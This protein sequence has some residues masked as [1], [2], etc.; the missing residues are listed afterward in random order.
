MLSAGGEREWPIIMCEGEGHN[1]A[2]FCIQPPL[3]VKRCNGTTAGPGY[4]EANVICPC[5]STY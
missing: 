3:L 4:L 2:F 5:K 1:F